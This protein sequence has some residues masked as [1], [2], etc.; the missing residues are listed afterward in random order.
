M[1]S[2]SSYGS[3][4]FTRRRFLRTAGGLGVAATVSRLRMVAGYT[5]PTVKWETLE[6]SVRCVSTLL[7]T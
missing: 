6:W 2:S 3:R 5:F 4:L 7:V 1:P